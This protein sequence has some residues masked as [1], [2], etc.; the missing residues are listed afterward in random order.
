MHNWALV[1]NVTNFRD[2]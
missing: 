2:Y 1:K